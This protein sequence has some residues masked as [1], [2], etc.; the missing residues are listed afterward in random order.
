MFFSKFNFRVCFDFGG[1]WLLSSRL[2]GCFANQTFQGTRPGM[3]S[4]GDGLPEGFG[5]K[6]VTL[7][8]MN[9]TCGQGSVLT[10]RH[11]F[12]VLQGPNQSLGC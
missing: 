11:S 2:S 10:A 12:L 1:T 7:C 3:Q 8:F 5:L 6:Q 9:L 4:T